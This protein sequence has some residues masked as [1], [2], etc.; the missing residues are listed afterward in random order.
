MKEI[1]RSAGGVGPYRNLDNLYLSVLQ[2]A[3]SKN[4]R[5]EHVECIQ[6]VVATIVGLRNPLSITDLAIFLSMLTDDVRNTLRYLHS[7]VVVPDDDES[8]PVRFFHQSFPDFVQDKERCTDETFLVDV[9]VNEDIMASRC[10]DVTGKTYLSFNYQNDS[11]VM[12]AVQYWSSHFRS[13]TGRSIRENLEKGSSRQWSTG[14]GVTEEETFNLLEA[15]RT[16]LDSKFCFG[17]TREGALKILKI[18][19]LAPDDDGKRVFWLYGEADVGLPTIATIIAKWARE[20]K[21]ILGGCFFRNYS[22]FPVSLNVADYIFPTLASQL[23]QFDPRCKQAL[24]D[25]LKEAV[26]LTSRQ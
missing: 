10:M 14:D 2:H 21:Q 17:G 5:K 15:D 16:R 20:E 19:L 26:M 4:P 12:Y 6:R 1:Q 18:G 7:V 24:Y 23:A 8:L 25:I 9:L 22:F 13:G 11:V 3:V